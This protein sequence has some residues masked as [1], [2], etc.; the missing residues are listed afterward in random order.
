VVLDDDDHTTLIQ[1]IIHHFHCL[2]GHPGIKAT[3]HLIE[4]Y[5]WSPKLRHAVRR[6]IQLCQPCLLTQQTRPWHPP[7]TYAAPSKPFQT[8]GL[9]LTG[10]YH[11]AVWHTANFRVVLTA[12]DLLT[13]YSILIPL[14]NGSLPEVLHGVRLITWTYGVPSTIVCDNAKV[15]VSLTFARFLQEYGIKVYHTPPLSPFYGGWFERVHRTMGMVLRRLLLARPT[16]WL[17]LLPETQWIINHV[18]QQEYG[19]CPHE[20]LFGYTDN[21]HFLHMASDSGT[22]LEPTNPVEKHVINHKRLLAEF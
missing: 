18:S 15:F 8:I 14:Q 20:L 12:T 2:G 19:A 21:L 6:Y 17:T 1:D 9:D 3:R 10:P 5:F 4:R 22:D 11:S 7:S 16:D 13:K